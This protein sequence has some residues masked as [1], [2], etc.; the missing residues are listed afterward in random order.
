MT[1]TGQG[2]GTGIVRDRVTVAGYAVLSTW[3]WFLYGFGAI[4]PLLRTE[5]GI[6]RSVLGLHSVALASGGL[7]SGATVEPL[8]RRVRRRGAFVVGTG[9][10]CAGVLLLTVL[11]LPAL[12]IAAAGIVGIGGSMLVNT[13]AP[14]LSDHHG[15]TA[16]A[17]I[18]E[19]N[20]YAATVGLLAPT[21]V[22]LT[23]ALGWSWRPAALVV[24]P[25][26]AVCVLLVRRVPPGTPAVDGTPGVAATGGPLPR[27]ARILLVLVMMCVG[28][29]FCCAAWSA[30][31]LHT[32]TGMAAGASSAGVSA[33]V[34]GMA[35]GRFVV[36]RLALRY[37][38][39]RLL[40]GALALTG[41]GWL[42]AWVPT[43]PVIVLAGLGVTGLGIAALYPL[44]A[45]ILYRAAPGQADRATGRMS[46]T[47]A[48]AAG[49]GPFAL[50]AVADATST[51][52][53][54]V[55]VPLLATAALAALVTAR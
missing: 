12:T 20:A 26:A 2:S 14:T 6:S 23:V 21:A 37:P 46:L 48:L 38:S 16:A 24:L 50:G 34:G 7:V 19:G 36:G 49:G 1:T 33:V 17:A 42:I 27:T 29:E 25:L 22:G 31:L 41:V 18:S 32:R 43:Q 13:A 15:G 40:L 4:L 11:H 28:I 35:V 3:A 44:G 30:D 51:H 8:V 10:L 47:I 39:R 5:E 9:A 53:A 54:F 52:T 55:A 45:T